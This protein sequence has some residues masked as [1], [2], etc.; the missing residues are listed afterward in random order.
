MNI[1]AK[2]DINGEVITYRPI[3]FTSSL[4]E[5]RE[6]IVGIAFL[7][8]VLLIFTILAYYI[9]RKYKIEKCS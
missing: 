6:K 9:L 3:V 4:R 1:L 8:T 2:N 5:R 7:T